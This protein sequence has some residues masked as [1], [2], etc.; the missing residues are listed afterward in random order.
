[1][2]KKLKIPTV[3]PEISSNISVDPTE[4]HTARIEKFRK[5]FFGPIL[6]RAKDVY[7]SPEFDYIR[8]HQ[9]NTK[10]KSTG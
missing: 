8:E 1:M 6:A 5:A 3:C 9:Q 10:E 7:S 2:E 4:A